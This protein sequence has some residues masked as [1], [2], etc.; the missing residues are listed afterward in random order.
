M[1]FHWALLFL[2]FVGNRSDLREYR[3]ATEAHDILS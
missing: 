2:R 3:S 1:Y